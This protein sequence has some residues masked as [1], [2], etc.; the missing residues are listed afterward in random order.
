[1]AL[2]AFKHVVSQFPD[3]EKGPDAL[4]KVG[5][6]ELELKQDAKGKATLLSV[7]SKYPGTNAAQLAQERLHRLQRS[8]GN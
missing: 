7:V 2:D 3:S 6:T 4:L 1:M 8:A 5:F